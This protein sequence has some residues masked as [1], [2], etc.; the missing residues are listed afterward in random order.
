MPFAFFRS[1]LVAIRAVAAIMA[2][3]AVFSWPEAAGAQRVQAPTGIP[4]GKPLS[5]PARIAALPVMPEAGPVL[6]PVAPPAP[7]APVVEAIKVEGAQRLESETVVS[8]LALQKGQQATAAKINESV[9]ALFATG[10]FQDV[11][12]GMNG[13]ALIVRVRENPVVNKVVFE[14]NAELKTEDLE[15]EVQL[16]PRLVYTLP[17]VQRDVQRLLDLYR[18]SGRFAATVEPKLVQREQNRVDVIFEIVE[19]DKTGIQSIGFVG[20]NH[21]SAG[22]L[23]GIINTRESAWWRFFSSSD[24]YDPD[25]LNYDRELLRKFY[26]N[27]GYVDFRVLSANAELTPNKKDFFI[28]YTVDEGERYRLGEIKVVSELKGLDGAQYA[29]KVTTISGDW[30]SAAEIERSIDQLTTAVDRLQYAFVEVVP[31]IERIREKQ[32]INIVYRVREGPRMFVSRIDIEGNMRTMDK[33]IRRELAFAEGDAFNKAKLERS[34]QRIKDTGFFEEVKITPEEGAQPDQTAVK[35]AVK[36]KATG[37]ISFGAGY[38]TTDGPLGDFSIREKNFMGKGQDVRFGATL[39]GRTKQFDVSFTEPYFLDRD[40]AAGV[41]LFRVTRDNQDASSYDETNT[42]FSLR[43]GYPLSEQLRQRLNYTY[44]NTNISTVPDTASRF[45]REQQ[46]VANTS[47][48]GQELSYD[49]RDSR[50]NPSTGYI[51]HLYTDLAGLGGNVRYGRARVKAT[52]YFK[53]AESWIFSIEGEGGYMNGLG[54][55]VRISDRFFLGGDTLRGFE[56]SGVGP[57]DMTPGSNEDALGGEHFGRGTV[58]LTMPS[59]LPDEVGIKFHIF[60]DAGTIGKVAVSP[61]PGEDLRTD[62]S[63]RASIGLGATW[64]SPFGPVRLD[65]AHPVMKQSYDKLEKFRFNFGTRF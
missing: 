61:A 60:S 12:L 24:F 49:T 3:A 1:G 47:M 23:R 52:E 64:Q 54:E 30:Y 5:A 17:R 51:L 2:F 42:G 57:R 18:R 50:L 32:I 25:R 41:D 40:L 65:F 9:K 48:V 55:K 46:G 15:K 38:S 13:T 27:Q 63:I 31:D 33:V 39:S 26:L 4:M 59:G 28:T 6:A 20:N 19:G 37:E 22:E 29:D 11:V 58:E 8:Y 62:Q 16:K 43:L 44:Q 35:V 56:F 14:G 34:E 36:E 10:L 45:I 21:F 53:L 7:E